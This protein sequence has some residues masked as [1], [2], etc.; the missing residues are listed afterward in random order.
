MNNQIAKNI[1]M[2]RE[3]AHLSQ[4]ALAERLHGF[5]SGHFQ[6]GTRSFPT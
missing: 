1:K 5:A 6:L 2:Y 3:A 4:Q